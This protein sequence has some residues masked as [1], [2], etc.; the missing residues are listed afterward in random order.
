MIPIDSSG[1]TDKYGYYVFYKRIKNKVGSFLDRNLWEEDQSILDLKRDILENII[2]VW[3]LW[4]NPDTKTYVRRKANN[5][6][7]SIL[8]ILAHNIDF[9]YEKITD[10]YKFIG[11]DR[12]LLLEIRKE[13][14]KVNNKMTLIIINTGDKIEVEFFKGGQNYV[15]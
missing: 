6:I 2:P 15:S 13:F 1:K 10:G 3:N 7:K 8:D 5:Y 14:L 4:N 11:I 9:E 12:E